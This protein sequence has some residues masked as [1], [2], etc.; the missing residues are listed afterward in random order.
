MIQIYGVKFLEGMVKKLC[1]EDGRRILSSAV[2]TVFNL[3]ELF[4]CR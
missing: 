3:L 4:A 1:N 2:S